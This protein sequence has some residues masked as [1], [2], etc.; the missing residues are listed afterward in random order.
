MKSIEELK[1]IKEKAKHSVDMRNSKDGYRVA[2]GMA[3]CGIASGA[4]PVL[5]KFVEEVAKQNLDNIVVTQV[6]CIGVCTH[7]PV[8]EVIDSEGRKV[9]YGN[10]DPEKAL[11]IVE[12]HLKNNEIVEELKIS[13][14]E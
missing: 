11:L 1:K 7:E 2:I 6:G 4:K 3:T 9:I 14:V 10:I 12:K 8:V 5:N 13:N